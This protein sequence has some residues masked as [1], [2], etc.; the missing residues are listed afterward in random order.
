MQF[1]FSSNFMVVII[2]QIFI[3]YFG[4]AVVICKMVVI[5]IFMMLSKARGAFVVDVY[6]ITNYQSSYISG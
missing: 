2:F 3:D 4:F 6:S 5:P 1:Y